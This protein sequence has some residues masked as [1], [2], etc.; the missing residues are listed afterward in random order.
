M[1]ETITY[2]RAN[3]DSSRIIYGVIKLKTSLVL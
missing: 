2:I 3:F 1:K